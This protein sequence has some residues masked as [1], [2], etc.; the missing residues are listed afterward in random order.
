MADV[1]EFARQAVLE[2]DLLRCARCAG[3]GREIHHRRSRSVKGAHQ[4]CPCNLILLCGRGNVDGCHGYVHSHPEEARG[5]GLIV[6]RHVIEPAT[7]PIRMW[8]GEI[9]VRCDGSMSWL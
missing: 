7:I 1:S 9:V 3:P 8:N 4:H 6:S 2:R 5:T